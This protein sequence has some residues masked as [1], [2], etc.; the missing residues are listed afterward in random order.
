MA[1]QMDETN[2]K[3]HSFSEYHTELSIKLAE[4]ASAVGEAREARPERHNIA[5]PFPEPPGISEP[6][7]FGMQHNVPFGGSSTSA[8]NHAGMGAEDG[9]SQRTH[10]VEP[11]MP[12]AAMN[13]QGGNDLMSSY[14]A[15]KSIQEKITYVISPKYGRELTEFNGSIEEFES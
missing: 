3:I 2:G 12:R 1:K 6:P 13:Q 5:S 8:Q 4:I 7:R 10:Y 11:G 14:G 15:G 9:A